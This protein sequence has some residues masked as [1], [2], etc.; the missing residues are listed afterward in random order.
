MA[1][2]PTRRD[3]RRTLCAAE[4]VV[5]VL[6]QCS[7]DDAFGDIVRTAQRHNVAPLRL[8]EALLAA[9]QCDTG[10]DADPTA[11]QVVEQTWG[12]LLRTARLLTPCL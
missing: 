1:V 11:T 8:A 12:D 2:I 5:A 10:A 4:G 9:T 3:G 6:R 7:L